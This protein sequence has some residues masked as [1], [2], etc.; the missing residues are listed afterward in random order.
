MRLRVKKNQCSFSGSHWE[1]LLDILNLDSDCYCYQ[2]SNRSYK[3][4]LSLPSPFIRPNPVQAFKSELIRFRLV[5]LYPSHL[6]HASSLFQISH[7]PSFNPR[8][9]RW[10]DQRCHCPSSMFFQ[11]LFSFI[12]S[13]P[14]QYFHTAPARLLGSTP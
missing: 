2:E 9:D 10:D 6:S 3:H 8:R 5:K 12:L 11:F 4:F 13:P 1:K 7:I 14:L